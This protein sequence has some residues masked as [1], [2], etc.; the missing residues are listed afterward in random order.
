VE[1]SGQEK[2]N[3]QIKTFDQQLKPYRNIEVS[4]NGNEYIAVGSKGSAFTELSDSDLPIKTIEIKN[5]QLEAASWIHSKGVVEIIVRKKSYQMTTMLLRD[6]TGR[7]LPGVKVTFKGKNT[8]DGT[9]DREG[10][11]QIP[12]GLDERISTVNQFNVPDFQLK[13]LTSS[14]NE[15]ILVAEKI[16]PL[17]PLAEAP[18]QGAGKP[19]L[20]KDYFK[21]FDLSKLDSIQSLTVF[22]SIFKN[23]QIRDMSEQA[24]RRVDA[25]FNQLVKQLEDSVRQAGTAFYGGISD[26]TFVQDDIKSL[27]NQARKES[28]TLTDQ[29]IEFD[30]KIR[31]INSKLEAGISKLDENTRAQLLSDLALLERLL[32][33]NESRFF[34]NQNDYKQIIN[35][36][37]EKYFNFQELET[38]LSESEA[39]RLEEQRIFRQRL[40]A[41]S[42]VVLVFG[43]LIVLLITVSNAL[44]K[45]KKEL[46][47]ANDEIRRMN[48]NLEDLVFERTRMLAEANKELDTFLY[49]ASHDMRSPVCSIIGLCNIAS[50]LSQGEPKELID[51]VVNTTMGMDK[52]LK[53]LSVISEINQPTG[54]TSIT[55][56]QAIEDIQHD[57]AKLN[58]GQKVN[59]E[60]DCPADLVVFSYPNLVHTILSNLIEN[61]LFYSA[62]ENERAP[63]V[64]VNA[65][66]TGEE[67]EIDVHDNG[68]GVDPSINHRLFD[69]F[70][71]GTE[72]SKGHG[73]GLYIV[74]KAVQALDGKIEVES[75]L[76][77]YTKFRVVLPLKPLPERG[78]GVYQEEVA[79]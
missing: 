43:L 12:L 55:L 62:L 16:V 2:H 60:V 22:Y 64:R 17:V 37:K 13:S 52:L 21:D 78:N 41:I 66:I 8:F 3:V 46:A 72:K 14:G 69:M 54:F 75:E 39:Q 18:Q 51:R 44:R 57:L 70:F 79:A 67:V 26:S 40:L 58:P 9:T 15:N 27:I 11:V 76:G 59:V 33:E 23:Y 35:A 38:K 49:R 4:I 10:K 1:V 56:L 68:V 63:V 6:N 47:K 19:L 73:L 29:R 77:L 24:K 53:K 7:A 36:I 65:R 61:G 32:I 28:Q 34:K 48:D 45:Q 25:K 30:E 42:A 20:S 5:D 74:S 71:K 50:H 31:M